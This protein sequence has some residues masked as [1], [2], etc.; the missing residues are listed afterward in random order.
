MWFAVLYAVKQWPSIQYV[1]STKRCVLGMETTYQDLHKEGIEVEIKH[2]PIMSE[3][4]EVILW[5][6]QILGCHSPTALFVSEVAKNT[7]IS[8]H[9]FM[10]RMTTGSTLSMGLRISMEILLT[11]IERI[12]WF[13]RLFVPLLKTI[14]M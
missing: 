7:G 14:A 10:E 5:E 2:V 13:N 9:N 6:W 1:F 4:K 8:F 3:E 11:Y 12:K